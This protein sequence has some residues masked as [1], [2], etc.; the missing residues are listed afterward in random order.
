MNKD[1]LWYIRENKT[2]SHEQLLYIETNITALA[3][4]LLNSNKNNKIYTKTAFK[5]IM[6]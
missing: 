4:Q 2:A 6:C 5:P 3:F 1:A